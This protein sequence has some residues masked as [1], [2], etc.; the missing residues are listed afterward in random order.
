MTGTSFVL[1]M[2]PLRGQNDSSHT[3]KTIFWFFSKFSTITP[4]H[5]YIYFH[6]NISQPL[7]NSLIP[8][9]TSFIRL[10]QHFGLIFG[11]CVVNFEQMSDPKEGNRLYMNKASPVHELSLTLSNIHPPGF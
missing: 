4:R 6:Y 10:K 1:E 5:F 2:V 9:E 8:I 3:H 11:L 7:S